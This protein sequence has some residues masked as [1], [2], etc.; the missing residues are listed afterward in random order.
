[1]SDKFEIETLHHNVP[2]LTRRE[3][4]QT[5]QTL[6]EMAINIIPDLIDK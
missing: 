4:T 1:M 6:E 3:S 5:S 2:A